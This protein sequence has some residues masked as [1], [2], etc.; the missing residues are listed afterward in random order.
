MVQQGD[1]TRHAAT[2]RRGSGDDEPDEARAAVVTAG[3]PKSWGRRRRADLARELRV[4][5]RAGGVLALLAVLAAVWWSGPSWATPAVAVVA[6]AGALLAVIDART[7]RLPDVIVLP[8][9]VAVV[10]LLA[11]ASLA[12]R[13]GE[14]LGRA[15]A[16][17][18]AGFCA[19][20]ALRLAHPPGL[21]F[22]D[23]KLAGTLGAPLAWLGWAELVAGLLLPFLLGGAWALGL[24]VLRRARRDTAVA[25]GPFM[26]LGA[27]LACTDVTWIAW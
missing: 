14:P 18:A 11:V 22:G 12:A 15:L 2:S 27:V 4:A 20:A 24:V 16:G 9:G 25:F 17:G 1:G 10:V 26:V 7:H 3:A 8:T 6:A 5:G 23:V 21:G 19:Y 13:D